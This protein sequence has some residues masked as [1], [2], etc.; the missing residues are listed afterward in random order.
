MVSFPSIVRRIVCDSL[1]SDARD[2]VSWNRVGRYRVRWTFEKNAPIGASDSSGG[3]RDPDAALLHP[4]SGSKA[5]RRREEFLFGIVVADRGDLNRADVPGRVSF[6]RFVSSDR[7][8]G[9]G[10]RAEPD[11]QSWHHDIVQHR[12]RS[13]RPAAR[14]IRAAPEARLPIELDYLRSRLRPSLPNNQSKR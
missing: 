14:R 11:E 5:R 12:R 6:G 1:Q 7:G 4:F 9:P 2:R 10:K 3:R 8:P 13:N